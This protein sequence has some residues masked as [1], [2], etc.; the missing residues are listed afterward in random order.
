MLTGS[1]S[2]DL[3]WGKSLTVGSST[4]LDPPP[5]L[6]RA[7]KALYKLTQ[8]LIRAYLYLLVQCSAF[9]PERK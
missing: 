2:T 3:N 4:F 7:E 1:R 6:P 5:P 8:T 9:I